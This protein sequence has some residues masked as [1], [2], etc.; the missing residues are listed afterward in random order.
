MANSSDKLQQVKSMLEH[1]LAPAREG[2]A[3]I[4]AMPRKREA[5]VAAIGGVEK[6]SEVR[7]SAGLGGTP[8]Q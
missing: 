8:K 2:E 1:L 7:R 6:M 3:E 4:G 5:L